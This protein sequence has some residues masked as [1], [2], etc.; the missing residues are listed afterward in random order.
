[1]HLLVALKKGIK[2]CFINE[3]GAVVFI[4]QLADGRLLVEDEYGFELAINPAELM[5]ETGVRLGSKPLTFA[6]KTEST[7]PDCAKLLR[8]DCIEID[9]H[10]YNLCSAEEERRLQHP[11]S[12]QMGVLQRCIAAARKK[13]V[14]YV[15]AIHGKGQGILRQEILNSLHGKEDISI[16][17]ASFD[18]YGGGALE[19]KLYNLN[20]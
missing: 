10:L 13:K 18:R 1:M 6:E 7:L 2:L 9:L 16:C 17:D 20:Q 3:P 12:F 4:K 8:S 14:R 5:T 15:I 19:I 11:L